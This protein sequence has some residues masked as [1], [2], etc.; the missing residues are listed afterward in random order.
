MLKI[1]KMVVDSRI[2]R[3]A[4]PIICCLGVLA[5]PFAFSSPAGTAAS[6]DSAAP[7]SDQ[8]TLTEVVVTAQK[9]SER[10]QD[11]PVS[12][13]TVDASTMVQQH[14]VS[15]SDYL[16][17]V[18]GLAADFSDHDG[19]SLAIRGITT[20]TVGGNPT[21]GVTIDDIPIDPSARFTSTGMVPEPH[22]G[23]LKGV[24][25]GEFDAIVPSRY[26]L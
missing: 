17:Q 9:R 23:I 25:I 14:L 13:S 3:S 15:I 6:T 12:V 18:P 1:I 19:V 20:G 2:S 22:P 7:P 8:Q 4:T 5:S 24:A 16:G 10:L 26:P 21:V 11:I